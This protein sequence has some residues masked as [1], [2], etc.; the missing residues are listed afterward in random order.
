MIQIFVW[1]TLCKEI[2]LIAIAMSFN[3]SVYWEYKILH[4]RDNTTTGMI[5]NKTL[6]Q[7]SLN[8]LTLSNE[9]ISRLIVI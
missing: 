8:L 9:R 6:D 2:I 4:C 7:M 5:A 1:K 3:C